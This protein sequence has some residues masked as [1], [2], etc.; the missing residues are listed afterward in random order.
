M[1]NDADCT[2]VAYR[3]KEKFDEHVVKIE[4]KMIPYFIVLEFLCGFETKD[5]SEIC[6]KN[7]SS[8]SP[9]AFSIQSYSL[10]K[11]IIY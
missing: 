5:F 3:A 4:S 1:T 11:F 7:K 9:K 2:N 10:T 8:V 6:T